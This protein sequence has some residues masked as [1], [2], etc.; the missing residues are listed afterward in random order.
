MVA[1]F[2]WGALGASALLVGALLAYRMRPGRRLIAAVMAVGSGLLLGSV[3]FELVDEALKSGKVAAVGLFVL[4]GAAV[5][6]AGDWLLSRRGGGDRKDA[7]GDQAEGSPLAIVL[8]SV[9]DGIPE[10]FVL[11]LTVL[12]GQVS[13]ALLAAV[14]LSNLPEGMASSAGLRTAGWPQRRVLLMWSAVVAVSAVASA[15][16]YVLLDSGGGTTG[17]L[18]QAFAAGALLAMLSDTM[19][20]EAYAV[21]GPLTGLLVVSGFAVSIALS[22]A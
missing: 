14:L 6:A 16:G 1:A 10:S 3:S 2:L 4:I 17:A 12:Q 19:L 22:A 15:A 18:V 5:F 11:G 8:G 21:E 7:G 20:P 13:V 9:L